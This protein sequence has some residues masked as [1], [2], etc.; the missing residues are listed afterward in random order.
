M[1]PWNKET[2]TAPSFPESHGKQHLLCQDIFTCHQGNKLF[3]ELFSFLRLNLHFPFLLT[4]L[5]SKDQIINFLPTNT[6]IVTVE[7]IACY[8]VYPRHDSLLTSVLTSSQWCCC[9]K[10]DPGLSTCSLC[11]VKIYLSNMTWHG[12]LMKNVIVCAYTELVI[13][14]L[15]LCCNTDLFPGFPVLCGMLSDWCR[16]EAEGAWWNTN[17]YRSMRSRSLCP[18]SLGSMVAAGNATSV[19]KTKAPG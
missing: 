18:L 16:V 13:W 12:M 6:Y 9:C 1:G 7:H 5:L 4:F 2:S 15:V 11:F 8:Y 3:S 19:P 14:G 17:P 10:Q